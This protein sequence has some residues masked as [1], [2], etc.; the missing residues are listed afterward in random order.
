MRRMTRMREQKTVGVRH[1]ESLALPP[2]I[3]CSFIRFFR[4]ILLNPRS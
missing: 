3:R 1:V 4:L 2:Q